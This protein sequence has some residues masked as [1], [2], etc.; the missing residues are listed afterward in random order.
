MKKLKAEN[1][2]NMD[3]NSRGGGQGEQSRVTCVSKWRVERATGKPRFDRKREAG[4]RFTRARS[5][6]LHNGRN[7]LIPNNYRRCRRDNTAIAHR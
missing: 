6:C 3:L 1:P 7:S 4:G 5:C 2:C